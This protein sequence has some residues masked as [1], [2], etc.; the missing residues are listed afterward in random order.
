MSIFQENIYLRPILIKDLLLDKS[1][2]FIGK[3]E[4]ELRKIIEKLDGK[5]SNIEKLSK[6]DTEKLLEVYGPI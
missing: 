6:S 3:I 4:N 1:F 5:G 2:L